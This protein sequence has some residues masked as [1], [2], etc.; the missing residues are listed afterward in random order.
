MGHGVQ[1]RRSFYV[2]KIKLVNLSIYSI[3]KM[4][5]FGRSFYLFFY[6]L[7]KILKMK[8]TE[9]VF[10][11]GKKVILRPVE[12]SDLPLF[13]KWMNDYDVTQYLAR[14]LP[15]SI[16]DEQEWFER[17]SKPSGDDVSLAI[18]DCKTK[19][20]IGS[21]GIHKINHVSK[22]A[23]TGTAI[24]DKSYW[25]KGY[26]TEAKMLLL[27]FAFNE[28]NLRKIY[29]EVI[30]YNKRSISYAK[31]CGYVEEARLPNHYFK[32][33]RYWDQVILAVYKS[34]WQKIWR[35]YSK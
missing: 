19:K 6:L 26:G 24:G 21:L 8:K 9:I 4:T 7:F 18:L 31:T 29:S 27:E 33:G 11:Q 15:A 12:E 23:T 14:I 5:A 34:P 28:L 22:T 13:Q 20:L 25:G 1:P 10:R 32:K 17:I 2:W 30:G 3:H 35:E 16:K